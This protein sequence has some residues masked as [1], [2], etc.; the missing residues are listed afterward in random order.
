MNGGGVTRCIQFY[1]RLRFY[2]IFVDKINGIMIIVLPV[3]ILLTTTIILVLLM[4]IKPGFR[5]HWLI[6]ILGAFLSVVAVLFWQTNLAFIFSLPAWKPETIFLYSPSWL[7]DDV[8]W[9]YGLSLTALGLATISTAVIRKLS[10]PWNWVSILFLVSIGLLTVSAD[11]PL[12]LVIAWFAMDIAELATLLRMVKEEKSEE[13]VVGFSIRLG[14]VFLLLWASIVSISS[15]SPLNFREM[16]E[17]AGILLLLAALLRLGV[18]PL[19][20]P[21]NDSEQRRGIITTLR[22]ISAAS[23]LSL[24]ARIPSATFPTP[25][26]PYLIILIGLFTIF[27]GWR[28]LQSSD[29]LAG[30]P[31][32]ISGFGFLAITAMLL[33]NLRGSVAWGISLIL[34]GGLLFLN[35]SRGRSTSWLLF[36][37]LWGLSALPFS[38]TASVWINHSDL[39]NLILIPHILGYSFILTGYLRHAFTQQGDIDIGQEPRWVQVIYP[40]GLSA[41]P[42]IGI[43]ISLKDWFQT[44]SIGLWWVSSITLLLSFLIYLLFN[45]FIKTSIIMKLRYQPGKISFFSIVFWAIY[46]FIRRII[47]LLTSILEGDGGML[48]SIVIIV[49]FISIISQVLQFSQ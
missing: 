6:A 33:G 47:S 3:L 24:I 8:S 42:F 9:P 18:L 26:I 29:E 46:H 39:N 27:S 37:G 5:F 21:I 15:G 10:T 35:S 17:S 43:T 38:L 14:G 30:R 28:W 4:L 32:L 7:A 13:L 48:W 19:H 31:Y 40:I 22:L 41:L 2:G 11:N 36:I 34:S 1:M 12:T 44:G 23:G 20:L 49:L 16:P 25:I 45:R